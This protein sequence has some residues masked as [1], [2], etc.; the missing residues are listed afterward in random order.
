MTSHGTRS[1]Y[2]HH[3][4]RCDLCTAANRRYNRANK[5]RY[6]DINT[7]NRD[8]YNLP[9]IP[10]VDRTWMAD[11]A[12]KG[13]HD[14]FFPANGSGKPNRTYHQQAQAICAA[15][16]VA[17]QCREYAITIDARHGVWAGQT[18]NQLQAT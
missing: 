8:P 10:D 12:C 14:L 3:G 1:R 5:R 11:A 2:T 17:T 6:D 13:R 16:P 18:A 4:C 15:C 9:T 7:H